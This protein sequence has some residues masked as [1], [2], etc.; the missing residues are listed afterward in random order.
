MLTFVCIIYYLYSDFSFIVFFG[1]IWFKLHGDPYVGLTAHGLDGRKRK[2]IRS[3]EWR[4]DR[5][6]IT[7]SLRFK[8]VP[9]RWYSLRSG[10]S[11][12]LWYDL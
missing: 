11:R 3:A 12:T 7:R 9:G 8:N 1:M 6:R 10:Y 2:I 4:D 5:G